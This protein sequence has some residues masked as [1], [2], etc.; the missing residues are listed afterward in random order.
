MR[1]FFDTEFEEAGPL[2][3]IKFI[4]IG[5]VREDGETYYAENDGYEWNFSSEWL[6]KNVRPHLTGPKKE[7][8]VIA[9]EI[10]EFVGSNPEFWAD[11]AAYDWVALCQLFG[12][13]MDLPKGWPYFCRDIQQ[14]RNGRELPAQ[15]ST[16][17][18]ALNDA[19]HCKALYEHL[20]NH[21]T[22]PS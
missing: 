11:Y 3:R 10:K 16:E 6:L 9:Q 21:P 17:H 20:T 19:L 12:T 2:K 1:I 4:S 14:L 8:E 13:M 5:L 18:H 7:R 22:N 15:T